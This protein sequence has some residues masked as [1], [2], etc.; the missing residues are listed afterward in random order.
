MK[1]LL[2]NILITGTLALAL[3]ACGEDHDDVHPG[4]WSDA[5][6]LETFLGDTV[7]V[8]G[9]VS[10]YIG[11]NNVT[12]SCEEWGINKVYDLSGRVSS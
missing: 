12:I 11:M 1:H 4:L 2:F 8:Q 9:Q 5:N 3:T 10:N 6:V 7:L